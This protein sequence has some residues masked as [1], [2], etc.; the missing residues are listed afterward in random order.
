LVA[1]TESSS[2]STRAIEATGHK[3]ERSQDWHRPSRTGAFT[4]DKIILSEYNAR[5]D[6]RAAPG[7]LPFCS[8][9]SLRAAAD[10][11]RDFIVMRSGPTG[12]S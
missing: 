5:L 11:D 12:S 8:P 1:P 6:S 3:S 9:F 4:I 7:K 10:L 2:A